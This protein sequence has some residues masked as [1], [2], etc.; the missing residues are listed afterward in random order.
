MGVKSYKEHLR[1][2]INNWEDAFGYI[3]ECAKDGDPDVLQLA[4]RDVW[5]FAAHHQRESDAMVALSYGKGRIFTAADAGIRIAV[6]D[7]IK[8]AIRAN[9]LVGSERNQT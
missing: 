7:E 8:E 5:E 1:E 3:R 6:R 4:V 9:P 2:N